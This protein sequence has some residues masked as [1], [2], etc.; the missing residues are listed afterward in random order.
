MRITIKVFTLVLLCIGCRR[1]HDS[2][3]FISNY[4]LQFDRGDTVWV[5]NGHFCISFCIEPNAPDTVVMQFGMREGL[6]YAEYDSDSSF[7]LTVSGDNLLNYIMHN[8]ERQILFVRKDRKRAATIRMEYSYANFV[9]AMRF[10]KPLD[11]NNPIADIWET[12]FEEFYYPFIANTHMD[13]SAEFVAPD[14]IEVVAAYPVYRQGD[15]YICEAKNI[16]S[17]SL[18]FAYLNK[19]RYIVDTISVCEHKV[20]VYQ[21]KKRVLTDAEK[22]DMANVLC[23]AADFFEGVFG[24]SY[25]SE[26][27]GFTSMSILFEPTFDCLRQN[28]NF[29]SSPIDDSSYY[30]FGLVHEMGHRYLGEYNLLNDA[31]IPGAMFL[32][33]SLNVFMRMMFGRATGLYD[34]QREMQ[35]RRKSYAEIKGTKRDRALIDMCRNNNYAVVYDKGPLILD[36][37]A[38]RVGYDEMV[39]IVAEFYRRYDLKPGLRYEDFIATVADLHPEI[40]NELDQRLRSI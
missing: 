22:S 23:R 2:K 18:Q 21:M 19:N 40:A 24:E 5:G 10:G 35:K 9:G 36:E 39:R 32:H 15:S 11:A 33:E 8:D 25:W 31:G 14:S 29:M 16:I 13:I 28:V 4:K 6:N 3:S 27:H 34:W 12:S 17:H 20:P 30:A 26:R 37:F 1:V 7:L 38:Q